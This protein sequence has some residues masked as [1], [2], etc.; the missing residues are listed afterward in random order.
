VCKV[1]I[2]T[3]APLPSKKRSR[4]GFENVND[5]HGYRVEHIEEKTN[6]FGSR[7]KP[8]YAE[9]Q[10]VVSKTRRLIRKIGRAHV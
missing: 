2:I 10:N 9:L 4:E 7:S 8:Q 6:T 3:K 5:R 1:V